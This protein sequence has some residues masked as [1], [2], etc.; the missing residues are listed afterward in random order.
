M[1][2]KSSFVTIAIAAGVAATP[3]LRG[4]DPPEMGTVPADA[5]IA[6]GHGTSGEIVYDMPYIEVPG[7][8]YGATPPG[9]ADDLQLTRAGDLVCFTI[10]VYN[11]SSNTRSPVRGPG[12]YIPVDALVQF[13]SAP[14][15]NLSGFPG[16]SLLAEYHVEIPAPTSPTGTVWTITTDLTTPVAVP[17]NIWIF[18]TTPDAPSYAGPIFDNPPVVPTVGATT[19]D[20]WFGA[21]MSHFPFSIFQACTIRLAE[22]GSEPPVV[23]CNAPAVLWSPDHT[24]VDVTGA[25]PAITDPDT[26]SEDLTVSIRVF[27]DETEIPET[28]DGTGKHAPDFK[29]L[30]ANGSPGFWLRS[31]RRGPGDGRVYLAIVTVSDGDNTV[32]HVCPIA[33]T[34]HDETTESMMAVMLEADTRADD[35]QTQ[36]DLVGL[37][38]VDLAALG[39]AEH[40]L[41][42]E[43][44]PKQ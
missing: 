26:P 21:P 25:L 34:P 2:K 15:V 5:T 3:T 22:E 39:L 12:T 4:Q 32:T 13:Y 19:D 8:F 18:V 20:L 36:I 23:T 43:L 28:G 24:F 14:P 42:G 30:L 7:Q 41:S 10:S 38:S 40:G 9:I 16:G 29:T 33:V 11:G 27:S 1:N 6:Y 31:E 35:L 37:G 17:Q 44:G